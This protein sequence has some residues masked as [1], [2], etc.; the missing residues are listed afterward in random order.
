MKQKTRIAF[1]T[2]LHL[3]GHDIKS[4]TDFG[5]PS[6]I[7][8]KRAQSVINSLNPDYVFGLGD[9]TAYSEKI[10]W[11]NYKKW[12]SGINAPV[13]DIF[14]NHDRNYCAPYSN[15]TGKP[16]FNLLGRVS[17]TKALK[18]GTFVFVLVSEE[19][20]PPGSEDKFTTTIPDKRFKFIETILKKYSKKNNVFILSH[21]PVS[22]T[23]VFSTRWMCNN[24]EA[25]W[26]VSKKYLKLF[27]KY[28]VVAH[29]TGHTHIDYRFKYKVL[30]EDGSNTKKR[31]KFYFNKTHFLNLPCI[32]V[33]HGFFSGRFPFLVSLDDPYDNWD[34]NPLRRFHLY[35][36]D[37]G[38]CFYDLI[39]K[40]KLGNLLGRSAIYYID[41]VQGKKEMNVVTRWLENNKNVETYKIKLKHTVKINKISFLESDLSLRNHKNISIE[42]S[43]WF[44]VHK[45][46]K[47]L[48]ELS[49]R[50]NKKITIKGLEIEGR[51]IGEHSVLWKGR[52]ERWNKKWKENPSS[53]G[54]V[55]AVWVKIIFKK[56]KKEQFIK[57]IK[58]KT[59]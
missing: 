13:Y 31:G 17:D 51:N 25:W 37:K 44:R 46:K 34:N 9:S 5:S 1:F 43:N 59:K 36:E 24:P 20:S 30:K 2:D 48:V 57:D 11:K 53:L 28:P 41:L 42:K 50:F 54:K 29:L 45:N 23:T 12:L 33:A 18:I 16:Y 52:K 32:D 49:Q 22:G 35:I 4:Q 27:K 21:T 56:Q 47:G 15:N 26:P 39:T 58:I 40:A 55:D 6:K 14:G 38:P 19:Y 7:I 3:R 8:P 10:E